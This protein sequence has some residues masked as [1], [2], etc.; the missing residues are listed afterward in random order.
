MP[1]FFLISGY[2]ITTL[3]LRDMKSW[4]TVS[5]SA[6]YVRRIFRILPALIAY[7][8]ATAAAEGIGIIQAS[9]TSY[10]ASATFTCNIYQCDWWHAH[11]W[12]LAV[13]EQFYM[14]WPLLFVIFSKSRGILLMGL[15]TLFFGMSALWDAAQPFLYISLGALVAVDSE[16]RGRVMVP[17]S[18]AWICMAILTLE[19]YTAG[20]ASIANLVQWVRPL[21]VAG[22]FFGSFNS[23]R[24]K[25]MISFKPLVAVG[26]VSYGLYLWQQLFTGTADSY[27]IGLNEAWLLGL[28][29]VILASYFLVE[30]PTIRI[31]RRISDRLQLKGKSH[32][33]PAVIRG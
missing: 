19:S 3:L 26:T 7:L 10:I 31:G 12:S 8:V 14:V 25:G 21:I 6:F 2:I 24:L 9:G 20:P 28:P 27:L 33:E 22:L 5:I 30:R 1:V 16:R 11:L 29:V 23:P 18:I 13:E 15:T 4:G 32:S 17:S